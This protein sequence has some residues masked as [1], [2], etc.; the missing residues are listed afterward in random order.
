MATASTHAKLAQ[1]LRTIAG[2]WV[3]DPFRPN[4]QLS[5]FLQSLSTHPKLTVQAVQATRAL[6]D[7]DM[8]KQVFSPAKR[9]RHPL[10]RTDLLY[11][12]SI[13]E[14]N[15]TTCFYAPPLRP[16]R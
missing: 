2:S 14:K 10:I 15:T 13:V 1:K 11:S 8:Q 7:N 4:L 16:R 5:T 3:K 12:V 6:R 9:F